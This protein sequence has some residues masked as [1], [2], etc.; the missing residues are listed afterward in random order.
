MR[1]KC[2][3]YIVVGGSLTEVITNVLTPLSANT[4]ILSGPCTP[5]VLI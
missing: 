2:T 1:V 3:F 4:N 5:A